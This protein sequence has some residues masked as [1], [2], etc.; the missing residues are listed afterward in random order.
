MSNF[1]SAVCPTTSYSGE[2]MGRENT[3]LAKRE[4][5]SFGSI[6]QVF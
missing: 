1:S 4:C 6:E 2:V 3:F 5:W